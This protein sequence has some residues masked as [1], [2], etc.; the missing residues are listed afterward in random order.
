MNEVLADQTLWEL[1]ARPQAERRF[2]SK[3][4][5]IFY[6]GLAPEMIDFFNIRDSVI[7]LPSSAESGY[8][9]VV[10]VGTTGSGKTTL[11]QQIIGTDPKGERFPSTS[12]GKTTV[13]E[14]ELLLDGGPFR[15]VVTFLPRDQVRDY[16]EECISRSVLAAYQ[17]EPDAEVLRHLLKHV[18]QRFRLDYILGNGRQVLEEDDNDL[19][20]EEISFDIET[21]DEA[22]LIDTSTKSSVLQSIVEC[23]RNIAIRHGN[24]LK[25]NLDASDEDER[26]IEEILEENLDHLIRDDEEFQD[27]VDQLM[28]EIEQRFDLLAAGRIYRTKQGWPLYW[29]WE[30]EGRNAFLKAVLRFSSISAS[31][32]GTL[33]T[34]LVNGIRVAGPFKPIWADQQPLLV[35]FDGEGLGHT[36]DS[37]ASLPTALTRRFDQVDAII[38][39]DNATQPMQAAAA[40]VMSNLASSGKT[41]KPMTCFTHFDAVGGPNLPTF[42]AKEQHVKASAENVVTAIGEQLGPVAER[43]LRKRLQL[44]DLV[45]T[46]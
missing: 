39:V 11:G 7:Q 5:E 25:D 4:V 46:I 12:A 44:T 34:P 13:A 28:D 23:V 15:A 45:L 37:S 33:L 24:D 2:D 41:S 9:R 27:V 29:H 10:L 8:R 36:P 19:D 35:L 32:W 42:S 22:H 30:T 40:A 31:Y 1:S 18:S 21:Q 38:L 14:T 26:V 20:E 17:N 6:D 43:A 16:V 3:V